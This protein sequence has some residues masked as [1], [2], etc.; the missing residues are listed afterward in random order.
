MLRVNNSDDSIGTED[1]VRY[2]KAAQFNSIK[3]IETYKN[4]QVSGKS[5]ERE[6]ERERERE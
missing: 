2:L 1:A 6:R 5:G 3:A 4:Y